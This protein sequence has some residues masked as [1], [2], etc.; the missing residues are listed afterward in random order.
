MKS[1]K[2]PRFIFAMIIGFFSLASANADERTVAIEKAVNAENRS[3]T[4]KMR[5]VYRHPE[6]TLAFFGIRPDMRVLEILPGGGWYTEILAPLLKD[7]GRLTVASFGANHPNDYLR[8][9]HHKFMQYL[10]SN[11]PAYGAVDRQLFQ[12]ADKGYLSGIAS[13][14]QD[15]VLT[16]RN[17]HNWIRYGGIEDIYRSFHRVLKKGGVLGVVQHRADKGANVEQSAEQGYVPESYL[18]RLIENAG[19]E[20]VGKT[21]INANPKDTKDYPKGVWTLPPTWRL[22]DVDRDKYTAVGESDRMTLRFIKNGAEDAH[23][24]NDT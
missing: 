14:S 2:T 24:H 11:P 23:H 1:I 18:I 13:G 10:D 15:M 8:G 6:A 16:F 21:E 3:A 20:L 19:F 4:N 9:I 7:K 12:G 22:G 5:D 17:T